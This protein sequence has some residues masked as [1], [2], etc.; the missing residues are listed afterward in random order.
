M[1]V[2]SYLYISSPHARDVCIDFSIDL[3]SDI[4]LIAPIRLSTILSMQISRWDSN[5]IAEFM[6][7]VWPVEIRTY[8]N[9]D[10]EMIGMMEAMLLPK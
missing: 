7:F 10:M 5:Q 8:Y 3:P 6:S 9:V 4:T 2:L 1:S